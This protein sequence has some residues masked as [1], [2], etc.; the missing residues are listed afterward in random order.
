MAL[1]IDLKDK[2]ALVTGVTSGIGLGVATMMAK[3][4]CHVAGCGRSSETDKGA[5]LFK[6]SVKTENRKSFYKKIDV[7]DKNALK[8]FV[9][10]VIEHFK[11]IDILV[12]NAGANIFQGAELCSEDQWED[13]IELNLASH[14]RISKFCK[15]YLEKSNKGVIIIMTS[16]HAFST[17]P[18]CFPYNVA[19]TSLT[20]LTKALAI[21]WGPKIRTIG[22][23]PGFIDTPGNQSWFDKFPDAEGERKKTIK[24]HPVKRL[25]T[26]QEVGAYCVFLASDYA[27]F[28]SGCTYLLDGGRSALMQDE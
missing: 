7:T 21:E 20:G 3:A 5:L 26:V 1:E 28:A 23:A 11:G 25:G 2:I 22:L 17:I 13:N 14:W 19:K 16:N 8:R 4:G 6:K 15:P 10:E 24:M 18:G 9:K 27:S 12:S